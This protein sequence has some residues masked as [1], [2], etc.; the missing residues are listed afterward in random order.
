MYSFIRKLSVT[1]DR[2][3]HPKKM[4][5]KQKKPTIYKHIDGPQPK[6]QTEKHTH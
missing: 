2:W 3:D 6:Q 5:Q 1:N 4:K